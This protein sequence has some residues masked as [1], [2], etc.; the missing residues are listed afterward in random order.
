M[1]RVNPV[2]SGIRTQNSLVPDG[3]H[4]TTSLG[5]SLPSPNENRTSLPLACAQSA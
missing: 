5:S 1:M 4:V 3:F 2:S